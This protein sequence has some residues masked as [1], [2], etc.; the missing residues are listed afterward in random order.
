MNQAFPVRLGLALIVLSGML[1]SAQKATP[2][3]GV[4]SGGSCGTHCGTE[5]WTL[6]TLTDSSSAAVAATTPTSTSISELTGKPAPKQLPQS[7]R[8]APIE[9]QQFTVKALLIAWKAETGAH[10]DQDFHLVLADPRDHSQTR[11]AEVPSPQCASACSS[12]SVKALEAA[13]QAL[14]T[15]VGPA[16]QTVGAAPVVPP[17][18]VEVTGVG[19][20]DFDHGQDGLALNCI[21]IRPVLKITFQ[22]NAGNSSIPFKKGGSHN[23]GAAA[24]KPGGGGKKH[25]TPGSQ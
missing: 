9:N 17:K 18:M 1:A 2:H 7:S 12:A 25:K 10:G 11:I 5:R 6:K 8:V 24:N 16:P 19:F 3:H 22:G 13:R 23:C 4:P 15:E 20:F 14:T 21:E